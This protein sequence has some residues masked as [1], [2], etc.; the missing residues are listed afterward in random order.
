M[1]SHNSGIPK[2]AEQRSAFTC[3]VNMLIGAVFRIPQRRRRCRA[4]RGNSLFSLHYSG[5]GGGFFLRGGV[6]FP[7]KFSGFLVQSFPLPDHP[8]V[9][10]VRGSVK[11]ASPCFYSTFS[12]GITLLTLL[13]VLSNKIYINALWEKIP[14]P[15]STT[16]PTCS[17]QYVYTTSY[18][19]TTISCVQL[20]VYVF[21]FL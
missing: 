9:S 7:V 11:K 8:S 6:V 20:E 2:E 5:I 13:T 3:A 16:Y 21:E 4:K 10:S 18:T 12:T 1:C 15:Q 19:I 17:T 14:V